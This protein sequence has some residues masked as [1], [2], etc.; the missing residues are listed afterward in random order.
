M[1]T[2]I[3]YGG[4]HEIFD[5]PEGVH[6]VGASVR[7]GGTNFATINGLSID[8]DCGTDETVIL[9]CGVTLVCHYYSMPLLEPLM[10]EFEA[11]EGMKFIEIRQMI[12]EDEL[13]I[14]QT[15]QP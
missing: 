6:L 12:G 3:T 9:D 15:V 5:S 1:R 7:C 4:Y 2:E 14:V 13:Y 8:G 10:K 11:F